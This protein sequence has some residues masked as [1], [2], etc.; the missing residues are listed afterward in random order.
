MRLSTGHVE[1]HPVGGICIIHRSALQIC[2]NQEFFTFKSFELLDLTV[3]ASQRSVIRLFSIY[4]PPPPSKNKLSYGQF[5]QEFSSLL[6][7]VTVTENTPLL[8]GDFNIHVDDTSNSKDALSFVET[9]DSASFEQH[10]NV[11]THKAGHTLDL[12]ISQRADTLVMYIDRVSEL[13]SD[14]HALICSA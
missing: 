7:S 11:P 9:L 5:M 8:V 14:H 12:I 10:V 4:R 6:E 2:R 1:L 3:R 13:P